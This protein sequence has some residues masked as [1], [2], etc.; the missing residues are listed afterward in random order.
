MPIKN[1]DVPRAATYSYTDTDIDS[2]DPFHL[3]FY[4][5][6]V[7]NAEQFKA[8]NIDPDA[9]KHVRFGRPDLSKLFDRVASFCANEKIRRVAVIT[10]G[11]VSMVDEVATLCSRRHSGVAFDVHKEVFDF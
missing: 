3:E 11:P 4:L 9:Q 7:R 8:A 1:E 6:S 5:T 2:S 10:C